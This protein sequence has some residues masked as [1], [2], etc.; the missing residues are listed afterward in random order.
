MAASTHTSNVNGPIAGELKS[1]AKR[2]NDNL[3]IG[4]WSCALTSDSLKAESNPE[5]AKSAFCRTQMDVYSREG[6]GWSFWSGLPLPTRFHVLLTHYPGYKKEN[7]E[8]DTSWC[9]TNS[10]GKTLPHTFF[11]YQSLQTLVTPGQEA[12]GLAQSSRRSNSFLSRFFSRAHPRLGRPTPLAR[13]KSVRPPRSISLAQERISQ[14][15]QMP[16]LPEILSKADH[17]NADLPMGAVH[18]NAL[19]P[20][21][22]R[23]PP[24]PMTES[25]VYTFHKA[26]VMDAMVGEDRKPVTPQAHRFAAI[27]RRR[28]ERMCRQSPSSP[29]LVQTPAAVEAREEATSN[30]T[31]EERIMQRGYSDGFLT[32][33][34]FAQHGPAMSRLGFKAQYVQDTVSLLKGIGV[35]QD[36]DES[37]YQE[38]FW[39]GLNDGEG[40]VEK[41]IGAM[42]SPS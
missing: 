24:V 30:L 6:G 35:V 31:A 23:S 28:E 33:K 7:C 25:Q 19:T 42:V 41:V 3:V 5:G 14:D 39:K 18:P 36:G 15:V 10:V 17:P 1:S 32:A 22:Y 40:L 9:F 12:F 2:L 37:K 8:Y 13:N 34:M 29:C 27:Q 26:E 11:S 16:P 20:T 38:W 4:E 21:V